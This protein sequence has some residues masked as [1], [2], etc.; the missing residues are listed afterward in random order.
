MRCRSN[1][2]IVFAARRVCPSVM[3]L[4]LLT[5]FYGCST[6]EQRSLT[7]RSDHT[8][9]PVVKTLR[10]VPIGRSP[11][12]I[13]LMIGDGMGSESWSTEH[14]RFPILRSQPH[15]L[16]GHA[17]H[18]FGRRRHSVGDR[19]QDAQSTRMHGRRRERTDF[20]TRLCALHWQ[21]YWCERGVQIM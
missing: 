18:R 20:S 16:Y 13:I 11:K 9:T 4:M 10:E 12:N 17:H 1:G 7:Y 15:L 2:H 14:G 19:V 21:T 6:E 3:A 8:Y 5:G